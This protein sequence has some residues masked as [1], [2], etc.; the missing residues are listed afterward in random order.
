[1]EGRLQPAA[2]MAGR[3][4]LEEGLHCPAGSG[5]RR[6]RPR[7]DRL[8]RLHDRPGTPARRR[9]GVAAIPLSCPV[10][11]GC[12]GHAHA[13]RSG[14][15]PCRLGRTRAFGYL[16]KSTGAG[17]STARGGKAARS[18]AQSSDQPD[19][20]ERLS[21]GP[22]LALGCGARLVLGCG[23]GLVLGCGAGLVDCGAGL[24]FGLGVRLCCRWRP[25]AL[26]GVGG[27]ASVGR[28]RGCRV[29]CVRGPLLGRHHVGCGSRGVVGGRGA[30]GVGR[31]RL[32][33][34]AMGRAG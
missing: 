18:P 33:G 24:V 23:A 17:M 8:G 25:R 1:M 21:C 31:P 20:L 7:L 27:V 12:E 10:R 9:G 2:E 34:G 32:A 19:V 28:R 15:G 5:R 13:A 16:V 29:G 26:R 30:R 22:M 6:G 11:Q 14:C 3:R 4:H